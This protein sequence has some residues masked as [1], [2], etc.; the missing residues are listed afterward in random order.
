MS[1][2]KIHWYLEPPRQGYNAKK[3]GG[4][5]IYA[6]VGKAIIIQRRGNDTWVP[7]ATISTP[8][9]GFLGLEMGVPDSDIVLTLSNT[10]D[11]FFLRNLYTVSL[12]FAQTIN[13]TCIDQELPSCELDL[14]NINPMVANAFTISQCN[15]LEVKTSHRFQ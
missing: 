13:A 3:R 1:L 11:S 5:S 7:V 8:D 14:S 9:A 12:C 2:I 6:P 4:P 15:N 10:V